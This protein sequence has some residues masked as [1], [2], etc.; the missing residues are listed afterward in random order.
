VEQ[1]RSYLGFLR[2][3]YPALK[4]VLWVITFID[5]SI[6]LSIYPS[7]HLHLIYHLS[8]HSSIH[9]SISP[10]LHT[11]VTHHL[12]IHLF[13]KYLSMIHPYFHL[14][15]HTPSVSPSI[16]HLSICNPSFCLPICPLISPPPINPPH[17]FITHPSNRPTIHS[18]THSS[19]LHPSV[20]SPFFHLIINYSFICF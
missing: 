19:S 15:I 13:I 3:Y 8:I 4:F 16:C 10:P 5:P 2:R 12:S 7:I 14:P 20:Y 9:T 6:H 1:I 11:S 17:P 18:F